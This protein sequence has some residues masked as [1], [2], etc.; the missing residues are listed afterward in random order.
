M[1]KN[2][3]K[4]LKPLVMTIGATVLALSTV[5]V[6]NAFST[7]CPGTTITS[8]DCAACHGSGSP[9]KSNG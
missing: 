9:Q 4:L 6:A 5:N 8:S 1:S 7:K 3:S 2:T